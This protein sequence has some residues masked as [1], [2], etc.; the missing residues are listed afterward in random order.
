M[1][2]EDVSPFI[3][4][5]SFGEAHTLVCPLSNG[6][7]SFLPGDEERGTPKLH[8]Y[9]SILF[10]FAFIKYLSKRY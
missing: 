9:P 10:H 3:L 4:A 7:S 2:S 8:G 5:V 6:Y 1:F